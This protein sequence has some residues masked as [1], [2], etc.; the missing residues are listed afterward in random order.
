MKSPLVLIHGYAN[1]WRAWEPVLPALRE[2]HEVLAPTLC[3]HFGGEPL[4]DGVEATVVA[5][6]DGVE[7]AMDH[8]GFEMAH[9]CGNSLGGWVALELGRRG[10]ARSVNCIAP[11]GGWEHGSR[12]ERRLRRMFTIGRWLNERLAPR[13]ERLVRRP[14]VRRLLFGQAM[15]HPER[16]S[17]AAAADRI[18]ASAGCEVYWELMRAILRDPLPHWVDEVEVPV[19]VCWPEHDRVLP[20]SRY[21]QPFRSAEWR[22]LPGVGHVPMA[23]D[24]ELVVRTILEWT[25]AHDREPLS[26]A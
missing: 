17:P 15:R 10:R 7:R 13:A 19:L 12:D 20:A 5:L 24:P 18:R 21:S 4:A 2:H 11:A 9:V 26:A 25:A 1:T 8:A 14:G 22:D 6:T 16:L 3:G 23:D